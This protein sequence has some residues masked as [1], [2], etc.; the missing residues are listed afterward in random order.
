M[1]KFTRD[2]FSLHTKA[3]QYSKYVNKLCLKRAPVPIRNVCLPPFCVPPTNH[4]KDVAVKFPPQFQLNNLCLLQGKAIYW[5]C[6]VGRRKVIRHTYIHLYSGIW[7]N[8]IST[9]CTAVSTIDR[10]TWCV[11]MHSREEGKWWPLKYVSKFDCYTL[12][13]WD[14]SCINSSYVTCFQYWRQHRI[15]EAGY[16]GVLEVRYTGASTAKILLVR[17]L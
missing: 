16:T 15:N 3:L 11:H 10:Y 9:H 5:R 1:Y 13:L 6:R 14:C 4:P 12:T 8:S 17:I 2:G 7:H